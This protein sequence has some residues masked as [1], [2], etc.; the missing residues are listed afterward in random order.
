MTKGDSQDWTPGECC[1][2]TAKECDKEDTDACLVLML[3]KGKDG[4]QYNTGFRNAGLSTSEAIALLE[5]V[6]SDLLRHMRGE[7]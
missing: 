4:K 2:S 6:K 5:V 1:R 7:L 3:S